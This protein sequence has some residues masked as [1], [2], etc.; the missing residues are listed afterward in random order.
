MALSTIRRAPWFR[1]S[2]IE[3]VRKGTE[4]KDRVAQLKSGR[5]GLF[6]ARLSDGGYIA[7]FSMPGFRTQSVSFEVTKQGS[8]D[9]RVTLQ[10]GEAH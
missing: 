4:G 3:V 9:L 2:H 1:E 10:L 5:S 7:L 6:S 8:D